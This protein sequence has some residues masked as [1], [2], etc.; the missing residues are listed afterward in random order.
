[1]EEVKIHT[2]TRIKLKRVDESA[3]PEDFLARLREF[4]HSDKR[5]LAVFIFAL[6][7][8]GHEAQTSIALAI[9]SRLFSAK[10]EDFLRIVDE[11]Q[12]LLPED[13]AV[14]LYRYGTSEML[15]QYCASTV[16][17]TYLRTA[18]WLKKQKKKYG[19]EGVGH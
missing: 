5:I 18:S 11:V 6:H 2:G 8:E 14:N 3:L 13:L 1:M 7:S 17:P 9:K 16:Q 19:Q 15:A 4:A 10:N 12:L